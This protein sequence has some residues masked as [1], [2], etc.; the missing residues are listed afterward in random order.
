MV[1]SLCPLFPMQCHEHLNMTFGWNVNLITG[2]NGSGKSAFL[3]AL[4]CCL[5]ARAI[6]TGRCAALGRLQLCELAGWLLFHNR[7][8]WGAAGSVCSSCMQE[9]PARSDGQCC[10]HI[11]VQCSLG[12]D[13]AAANRLG[14]CAGITA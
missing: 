5:G 3:Q 12:L 9:G 10:F 4:Q 14:V 1:H 2:D 11:P 13:C 6:E 8:F 7:A